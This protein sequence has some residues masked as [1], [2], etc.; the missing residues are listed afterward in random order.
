MW[1]MLK[2]SI[3]ETSKLATIVK[4]DEVLGLRLDERVGYEIPQK[5]TD[6]AKTR[7]EYRKNGI[8][9]KADMLR[10]QIAEAGFILDD[11][12]DGGYKLKRRF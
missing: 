5:I 6:M 12:P 10:K 4:M 7:E 11:L 2:N 3:S 8:W 9:E 1:E